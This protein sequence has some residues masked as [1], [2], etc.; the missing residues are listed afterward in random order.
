MFRNGVGSM[1]LNS[2]ARSFTRSARRWTGAELVVCV[3]RAS[4]QG[5]EDRDLEANE[6]GDGLRLPRSAARMGCVVLSV[7][8]MSNRL[9]EMKLHVTRVSSIIADHATIPAARMEH[10]SRM[11]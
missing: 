1:E 4:Y 5:R 10:A 11:A 6:S 9:D 2:C 8:I 7:Q 3:M